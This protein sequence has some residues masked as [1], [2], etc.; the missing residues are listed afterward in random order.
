MTS[1][2]LRQ[3]FMGLSR[4]ARAAALVITLLSFGYKHG[5]P[6]TP[7]C[8]RRALPAESAFRAGAAAPTGRDRAVVEFMERDASDARVHGPARGVSALRRAVLHREGKS[9]LTVAIGCTGG[10]T[11]R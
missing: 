1:T 10:A 3:F 2:R 8:V 7:T 9:Y 5:V 6:W 11:A 4:D